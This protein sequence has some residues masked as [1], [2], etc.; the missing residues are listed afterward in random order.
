MNIFSVLKVQ[1]LNSSK[2]LFLIRNLCL[3]FTGRKVVGEIVSFFSMKCHCRKG[4]N[5]RKKERN[6]N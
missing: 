3:Y 1:E 4:C 5:K 6:C 2:V